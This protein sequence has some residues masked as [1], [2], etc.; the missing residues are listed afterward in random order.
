MAGKSTH[1]KTVVVHVFSG[2]GAIV[3]VLSYR[4]KKTDA[5]RK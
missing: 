5:D 2:Y 4:F 1:Q 3:F